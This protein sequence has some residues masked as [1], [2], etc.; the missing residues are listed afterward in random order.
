MAKK[1][2]PKTRK[3]A[4]TIGDAIARDTGG[5]GGVNPYAVGMAAAKKAAA[6]RR[7]Q[8]KAP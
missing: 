3:K 8:R 1:V 7:R 2:H 4:R 5:K 6:K